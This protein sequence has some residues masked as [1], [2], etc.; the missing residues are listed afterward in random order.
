MLTRSVLR[1]FNDL[2]F[3]IFSAVSHS[4]PSQVSCQRMSRCGFVKSRACSGLQQSINASKDLASLNE[5][6]FV[7]HNTRVAS[8]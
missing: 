5:N 8:K 7:S 3:V 1:P 4:S 6:V 2:T